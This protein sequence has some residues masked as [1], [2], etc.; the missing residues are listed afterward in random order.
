M[1]QSQVYAHEARTCTFACMC[2]KESP[3]MRLEIQ[4]KVYSG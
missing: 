2:E 1:Q 3:G 4:I